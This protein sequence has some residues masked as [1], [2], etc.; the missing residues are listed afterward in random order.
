MNML[1]SMVPPVNLES[2]S[3]FATALGKFNSEAIGL[4]TLLNLWIKPATSQ[5][6]SPVGGEAE[7][8]QSCGVA[9]CDLAWPQARIVAASVRLK[10]LL[11]CFPTIL[12]VECPIAV[13]YMAAN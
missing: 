10:W 11:D 1:E 4:T 12:E 8:R 7:E 3:I 13:Y 6:Q 5:N 9:W 2:I